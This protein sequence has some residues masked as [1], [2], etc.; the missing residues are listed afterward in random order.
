MDL[1]SNLHLSLA[2]IVAIWIT[3]GE[4]FKIFSS[5]SFLGCVDRCRIEQFFKRLY[6]ISSAEKI[7]VHKK[8]LSQNIFLTS[9]E[10]EN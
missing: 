6:Q 3:V 7:F 8:K 1:H 2:V 5:K 10:I 9:L 4:Y